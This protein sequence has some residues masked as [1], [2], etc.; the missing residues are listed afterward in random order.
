[1]EK[2]AIAMSGGVDSSCA[3]LLLLES[4]HEVVGIHALLAHEP[5]AA[6]AGICRDLGIALHVIDLRDTFKRKV[7]EP[8]QNAAKNGASLNPCALCNR[9]IKFGALLAHALALGCDKLATGHYCNPAPCG[10]TPVLHPAADK[11]KDQAYFLALTPPRLLRHAI[12]PLGAFT[13]QQSRAIIASRQI[14]VEKESQDICFAKD[15]ECLQND[16]KRGAALLAES[17]GKLRRIGEH[18][19]IAHYTQGQRHGLNLPWSEPLYVREI[20]PADNAIVVASR[21]M[22]NMRACE[23]DNLNFFVPPE[24]WPQTLFA[25]TRYNQPQRPCQVEIKDGAMLITFLEA[26]FTS[27]RGQVAAIYDAFGRL[28]AGGLIRR[29]IFAN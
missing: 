22:V 12:F 19:G 29:V 1:M 18:R 28:L 10:P 9:Q 24:L 20:I 27:A 21:H 2:I 26:C 3:A 11:K 13:K 16:G 5:P 25:K 4:G 14:A 7:I 23:A 6:L 17:G 8:F 15:R